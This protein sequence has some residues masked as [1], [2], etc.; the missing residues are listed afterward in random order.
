MSMRKARDSVKPVLQMI[1]DDEPL[2]AAEIREM[3]LRHVLASPS[4]LPEDRAE[5]TSHLMDIHEILLLR[6]DPDGSKRMVDL[7]T[8]KELLKKNFSS[9]LAQQLNISI[10]EAETYWTW[11]PALPKTERKF[12]RDFVIRLGAA[13]GIVVGGQLSK[14]KN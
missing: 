10:S 12:Y 5:I 7:A 6:S 8:A 1:M 14:N 4:P 2:S 13:L 9:T 3:M 11:P